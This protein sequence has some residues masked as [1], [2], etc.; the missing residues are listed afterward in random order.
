MGTKVLAVDD[1]ATMR[2]LVQQT[3]GM[4]GY[5]VILASDGKDGIEKFGT[6]TVD[7]V[8]TDIN[9]P[10]MDGITFIRELRKRDQ[11][12][13]I[14][15]LTTESE[16]GMKQKGAEAGA[17]GWIIKPFRPAQFLDIIKQVLQ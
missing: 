7:L 16:D 13:P 4:G 3:L 14:L 8:I 9:M 2:S 6:E 11:N 10:V 17:N 1:S 5:D 15:T 12:I